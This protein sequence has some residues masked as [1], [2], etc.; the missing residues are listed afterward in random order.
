MTTVEKIRPAEEYAWIELEPG[1]VIRCYGGPMDGK[2][3]QFVHVKSPHR[4]VF[5]ELGYPETSEYYPNRR[6][7]T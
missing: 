7:D 6:R 2:L 3:F 1:A 4:A 5:V